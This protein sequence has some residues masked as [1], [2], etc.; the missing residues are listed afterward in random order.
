MLFT[1]HK[2]INL[3]MQRLKLYLTAQLSL[4]NLHLLQFNLEDFV[5]VSNVRVV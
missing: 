3:L 1:I 5:Q 2:F 4:I